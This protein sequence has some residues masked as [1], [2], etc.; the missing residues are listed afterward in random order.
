MRSDQKALADIYYRIITESNG[1]KVIEGDVDLSSLYLKELP[2]WLS[3][4]EVKGSFFCDENKLTTLAGAPKTV[5]G[6]FWCEYN[7]GGPP[8]YGPGRGLIQWEKGGRYDK[9]P[10]N[11]VSFAKKNS[12]P[13]NSLEAQAM[14]IVH[15]FTAN[16]TY[17]S[18]R[19]KINNKANTD[20]NF[21]LE[22]CVEVV[23]K[24]YEKAGVAHM[25]NR[26]K[27]AQRFVNTN[28]LNRFVEEKR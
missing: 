22:D 8:I 4:V 9:D 12:L 13:W 24:K 7:K 17:R 11:L 10:I 14:F 1:R 21:T 2:E 3:D 27:A 6:G 18:L 20:K 15:E 26:I 16:P 25:D 5:G 19:D 28:S 23:C